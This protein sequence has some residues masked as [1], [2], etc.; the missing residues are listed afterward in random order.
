[1]VQEV[2]EYFVNYIV[3]DSLGIIA[4]AHTVFADRESRKA[5]SPPCIELAKLFSIAV[6]FPKTGVPAVIPPELYAKEYPDFMEKPDK[7]TYLSNNVIGK[8]FREVKDIAPHENCITSFTKQVATKSYDPDMEVDGF[9]DYIEDA[10]YYKG[11]YDYKL[12]NLLDYYGIKTE[13]EILSGSIMGMSKYFTKRRDLDAIN[14]AVKSLRKE[15]RAWFNEKGTSLDSGVDDVYAKASAWYHVTYHPKYFGLY[16]EGMN[17][18]HFISFPWC[19]YDKLVHI[20]KDKVKQARL[21]S[22]LES[23]FRYGLHLT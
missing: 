4:N 10:F 1:V 23:R 6:D 14:M 2:E 19:V 12:G 17:R 7:R 16:N 9:E 21:L 5:M 18:D 11:N 8:L 20:K 22:S 13:A 3:N 15:A